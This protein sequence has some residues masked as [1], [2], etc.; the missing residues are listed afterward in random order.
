[1]KLYK[2]AEF[3][4]LPA[5]TIYS[6]ILSNEPYK[7]M[8]GLYCKTSDIHDLRYDWTEQELISEHGFPNGVEDWMDAIEY[9]LNLRDTFQD[10]RTD[11]ECDGRNGLYDENDKFVVWDKEDITKLRDYLNRALENIDL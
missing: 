5:M 8:D 6:K 2:R 9:Q 11:L 10:F 1:M 7:L 4:K 3:L